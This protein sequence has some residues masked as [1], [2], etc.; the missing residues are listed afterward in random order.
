MKDD[1]TSN[2]DNF[3]YKDVKDKDLDNYEPIAIAGKVLENEP[4]SENPLVKKAEYFLTKYYKIELDKLMEQYPQTKSLFIDY[5]KVELFDPVFAD[6]LLDKPD[7]IMQALKV[8]SKQYKGGLIELHTDYAPIIRIFNLPQ[9]R[10]IQIKDLSS[11]HIGKLIAVEGIIRQIT[12]VLPRIRLANWLCKK[13]GNEIL[14]PQEDV[15]LRKPR[16]CPECKHKDFELDEDNSIFKDYQKIEITEPL[17]KVKGGES[18]N[19]LNIIVTEDIVNLFTAGDR[20]VFTGTLRL[21]KPDKKQTIYGK[22]LD[23]IHIENTKQE[24][25]DVEITREDEEKIKQLANN[26]EVYSLISK[27]VAPNIYG[28]DKIKEA[29]A[30]QLFGGVKKILQDKS[31]IR[32]NI[33]ILLI[34]DPG[35][36]KSQLLQYT[37]RV[38]PKSLYVAGKTASGAGLT[39]TAVKDEFGEG[40]WTLK[41]GALVLA[42]GGFAM[43]DEFDKMNNEDRSSMHEAMEQE[44]VSIAKAGIIASF[45][46]ETSVLAAANPKFGRFDSYKNIAEQIDIPPTLMSRFDLFFVMRDI[47]DE[48][49]DKET[50]MS[51]LKTHKSGEMLRQEMVDVESAKTEESKERELDSDFLRKYVSYARTRVFPVMTEKAMQKIQKF[52]IDMR[53]MSQEG[54]VAVTYRQLEALV[55]L[56]EASARIRLSEKITEEDAE[57]AILLFKNSMEQVGVD[58]ET[59]AF[60]IDIIATGQSRSQINKLKRVME[61]IEELTKDK[62]M[63]SFDE[64]VAEA[65][66][67]NIDKTKVRE[68]V[69]K[70]TKAG[71]IYEPRPFNY[72]IPRKE[73][74]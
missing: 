50:V 51:I 69:E 3:D 55:R 53:R 36:G 16:L 46:T 14:L 38:A 73:Q 27:S 31:K 1:F 63:I 59:G 52:F 29:I 74:S 44:T 60:D 40:G 24:Y 17:D 8:A 47:L 37:T 32:G 68:I 30:M 61:L 70:L 56:S 6:E 42:S 64:L 58:P 57:R 4:D 23:C 33:H 49:R 34:G 10:I 19:V 65:E 43:V 5:S 54:R 13:C 39:A 18:T 45:K 28:H 71:D 62:K 67:E 7:L 20:I 11:D 15:D 2:T 12:N 41:A 66:R 35:T 22:Y 25:E 9:E 72:A 21:K 48:K 26:P